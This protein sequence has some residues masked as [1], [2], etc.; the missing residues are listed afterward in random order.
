MSGRNFAYL[1]ASLLAIGA[2]LALALS[3]D[4]SA[5]IGTPYDTFQAH[6]TIWSSRRPADYAVS[7]KRWCYCPLYSVRVSVSGAEV[8]HSEFLNNPTDPSVFANSRYPRDVDSLFKIVDDAYASRAYK[9]DVVF[10]E[11]YG[12]PAK[13][14]IDRN[15]DA[16]DDENVFELSNFQAGHAD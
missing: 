2:A 14:F 11:T 4:R 16:V 10:D 13:A 9:I 3:H 1:L 8:K 5:T 12:Y 6:R 15:A 7:I